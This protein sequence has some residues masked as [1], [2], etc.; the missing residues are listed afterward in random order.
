MTPPDIAVMMMTYN[1]AD[2]IR[3]SIESLAAQT[4]KNFHLV[5]VDDC[6]TDETFQI[7]QEYKGRFRH[8]T[9]VRNEKNKGVILNLH[10]T[11]RR[12]EESVPQADF[13]IW[14]CA[15]DWWEPEFLEKMRGRLIENPGAAVC[16]SWFD[17]LH[18]RSGIITKHKLVSVVAENYSEAKRVFSVHHSDVDPTPYNFVLHG[19]MRMS[20]MRCVYPD[21]VKAIESS[22][23]TELSGIVAML[24]RG[25]IEIHPESLVH[26]GENG[27][28]ADNNPQDP[29]SRYYHNVSLRSWA[30]CNQLPHLVKI[31]RREGRSFLLVVLLWFQVLCFYGL[32]P[33]G[34]RVK[35]GIKRLVGA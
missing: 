28:F 6:S 21:S 5:F 26:R 18:K 10:D 22:A 33:A 23:S 15:D 8:V 20:V 19:L 1:S 27:A 17:T 7:A 16:Q 30:A 14:A 11:L 25:A 9:M 4:Y 29:L 24:L 35:M 32:I 3:K 31:G 12:I 13:F 34:G 2:D